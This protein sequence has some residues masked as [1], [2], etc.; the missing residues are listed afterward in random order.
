MKYSTGNTVNNI[1]VAMSGARWVPEISG[2][3]LCKA[4]DCL[5]TIIKYMI[6]HLKL[7]QS[8]LP[9]SV[10]ICSTIIEMQT[11]ME[12]KLSVGCNVLLLE[13]P[14]L[15]LTRSVILRKFLNISVPHFPYLYIQGN[16]IS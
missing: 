9:Q 16:N 12:K 14:A 3:S 13:V 2:R 11:A 1:A 7:I 10:F 5:T 15:W 8:V 4:Y 6:T